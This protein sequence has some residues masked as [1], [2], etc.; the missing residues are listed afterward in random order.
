M[1]PSRLLCPRL[2][3]R[4]ALQA[5]L[6][7]LPLSADLFKVRRLMVEKETPARGR[8]LAGAP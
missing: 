7:L 6:G 1:V 8:G 2:I 4:I 5:E 3:D